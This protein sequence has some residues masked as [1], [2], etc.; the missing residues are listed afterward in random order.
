MSEAIQIDREM[1]TNTSTTVSS[2]I[3]SVDLIVLS[4]QGGDSGIEAETAL[5]LE[6]HRREPTLPKRAIELLSHG[7][8]DVRWRLSTLE[9]AGPSK[10]RWVLLK[11]VANL[12][13]HR[14]ERLV[15]AV[16]AA[17]AL[18]P[19]SSTLDVV[20]AAAASI[21][22]WLCTVRVNAVAVTSLS[23]RDGVIQT[24]AHSKDLRKPGHTHQPTAC[25]TLV[26]HFAYIGGLASGAVWAEVS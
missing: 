18:L 17:Y 16:A 11:H 15:L 19:H 26:M 24:S 23:E 2:E 10:H 13:A 6:L 21:D 7:R 4:N 3:N 22:H 8:G 12:Q 9:W 5:A 25:S 20:L 1:T 14:L